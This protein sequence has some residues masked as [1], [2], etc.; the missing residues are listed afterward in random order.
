MDETS[1][2]FDRRTVL[3]GA[4]IVGAVVSVGPALA[5]CGSDAT[6]AADP[7]PTPA[8][9]TTDSGGSGG[10]QPEVLVATSDVPEGGGVILD[11]SQVVVTQP[12]AGEFVAF[13][14]ICTHQGCPVADV[15]DGTINCN[16]HGS[17]F[18]VED[19]SVVAGPASSPLP[20]IDVTV[21]GNSVVRA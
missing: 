2:S 10:G 4:A 5:A 17:R 12:T 14:S 16:C 7:T 11:Q 21:D 19:G 18:S 3:R 20:P 8:A 6:T 13:S 15:A 9:P 1:P